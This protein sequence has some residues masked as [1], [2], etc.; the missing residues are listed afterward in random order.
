MQ[1]TAQRS[2]RLPAS[3]GAWLACFRQRLRDKNDQPYSPERLGEELGVSGPT[4]RR[5]E[6]GT[7]RPHPEDVLRLASVCG[8]SQVQLAFLNRAAATGPIAAA[9]NRASFRRLAQDLLLAPYPAYLLD[10]LFHVRAWNTLIE[11]LPDHEDICGR[12]LV[13]VALRSDDL[14]EL[15]RRTLLRDFWLLTADKCSLPDYADLVDRLC[16]LE[17]F[18]RA[19]TALAVAEEPEDLLPQGVPVPCD[20]GAAGHYQVTLRQVILPPVYY[21]CEWRPNGDRALAALR[22]H[23]KS[24]SFSIRTADHQHWACDARHK[25]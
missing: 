10:D 15:W 8:L 19:W 2:T 11:V 24:G 1:A 14:P 9:P 3:L 22:A 5:W 23:V 4:V 17:G 16:E 25:G 7:G 21:I 6:L 18:D 20:L 12:N 13:E